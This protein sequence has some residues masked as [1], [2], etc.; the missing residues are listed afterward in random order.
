MISTTQ[1]HGHDDVQEVIVPDGLEDA[2]RGFDIGLEDHV[3]GLDHVEH[4]AQEADVEGDQQTA[5]LDGG[6]DHGLVE[7]GL[8]G[9][10]GDLHRAGLVVCRRG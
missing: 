5:T 4:L 6:I 10:A 8:L 2:G 9:L 7:A 1:V 3:G